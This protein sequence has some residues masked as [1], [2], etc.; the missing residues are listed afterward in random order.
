MFKIGEIVLIISLI[1]FLKQNYN[2][3]FFQSFDKVLP[4]IKSILLNIENKF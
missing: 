1:C 4:Q 2:T 3:H